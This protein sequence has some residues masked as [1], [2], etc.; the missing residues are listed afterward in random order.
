MS[1]YTRKSIWVSDAD[2]RALEEYVTENYGPGVTVSF[3]VSRIIKAFLANPQMF[4]EEI[5][6]GASKRQNP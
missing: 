5:R 4:S 3:Q 1:K 2:W 6:I